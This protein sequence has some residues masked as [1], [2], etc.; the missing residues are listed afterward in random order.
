M[1]NT[2][3]FIANGFT[4]ENIRLQPWRYVYEL[5]RH[6]CNS[7]KVIVITE[8]ALESSIEEWQEGF[9]VIET[10]KLSIKLQT[11]LAELILSLNPQQLWWSTTPRSIAFYPC[12]S[13]LSCQKIA[14]ITCPLYRWGELI[15]ASFSGIPYMQTKA[16]WSQRLVP[17]SIFKFFLNG[18]IFNQVVVQ[19]QNNKKILLENGLRAEKIK[20]LPVGIDEDD[21]KP[22][23]VNIL[24]KV[25]DT[26]NK[27]EADVTFLYLGALRPIRGF[28]ALIKAFPHVIEKNKNARLV[29]LARGA[30]DEQCNKIQASLNKNYPDVRFLIVSGWLSREQIWSYIELSDIVV[31]PFVLVPSDIPIAVLESLARG[32]PVVVS[33]V[34]GLPELAKNR[35]I[36][37]D[38]LKTQLFANELYKLSINQQQIQTYTKSARVFMES[39]PRW[40]DV[41]LIMDTIS[42]QVCNL[43]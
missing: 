12:L 10:K 15:R 4:K 23:D 39:Y 22:V 2:T 27:K 11:A 6:K 26:L 31:L 21:T 20:F 32:K 33:P 1:N 34:D 36:I 43:I 16:L 41:G 5:A 14:F 35:G 28:D 7:G 13:K 3:V 30:S 40:K 24:K 38:P 9:T 29:V 42:K 17:R 19:S 18:N 37:V 8:G 25:S